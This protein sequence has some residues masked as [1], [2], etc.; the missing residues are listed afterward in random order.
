MNRIH[1]SISHVCDLIQIF[2]SGD[3]SKSVERNCAVI[4]NVFYL[5]F[6]S[7]YTGH[8]NITSPLINGTKQAYYVN[9]NQSNSSYKPDPFNSFGVLKDNTLSAGQNATIS[10]YLLDQFGNSL[11]NYLISK[12]SSEFSVIAVPDDICQNS[13]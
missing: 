13:S 7:Y 6:T 3:A 9:F 1:N 12:N 5:N 8:I 10:V 11:S 4:N 2:N